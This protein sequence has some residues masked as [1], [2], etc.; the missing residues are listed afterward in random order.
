MSNGTTGLN[1]DVLRYLNRFHNDQSDSFRQNTDSD[2]LSEK[3]VGLVQSKLSE[4]SSK[5]ANIQYRLSEALPTCLLSV[6][7]SPTG[8]LGE[9]FVVEKVEP[10]R[11]Q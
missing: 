2:D 8:S 9:R 7:V 4:I 1:Q 11:Q 3:M 6:D 10:N 5:S